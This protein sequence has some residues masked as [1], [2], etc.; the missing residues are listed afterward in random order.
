MLIMKFTYK[1]FDVVYRNQFIKKISLSILVWMISILS[2]LAQSNQE[3]KYHR[4]SL[5]MILLSNGIEVS[6][7]SISTLKESE[8]IFK[9]Q[10]QLKAK[11]SDNL[12]NDIHNF[13]VKNKKYN[14]SGLV[15][16]EKTYNQYPI[17]DKY[18]MHNIATNKIS[19]SKERFLIVKICQN[20][21]YL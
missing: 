11:Y 15:S 12:F 3:E 2:I 14:S 18:D 10:L 17:P 4:S 9:E 19:L 8:N 1:N 20:M 21:L 6:E 16:I 7:D 5:H 13:L